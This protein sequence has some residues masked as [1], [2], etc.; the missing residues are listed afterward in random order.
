MNLSRKLDKAPGVHV[1]GTCDAM[2]KV[3]YLMPKS[4]ISISVQTHI[5]QESRVSV[6]TLQMVQV[7][8][9]PHCWFAAKSKKAFESICHN[10]GSQWY[11][12]QVY[13]GMGLS[14]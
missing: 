12:L 1:L 10:Y 3:L 7:V 6:L 5:I 2:E 8:I 14:N 9:V 11:L 4:R 13:F